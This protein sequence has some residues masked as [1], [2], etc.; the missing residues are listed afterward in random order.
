MDDQGRKLQFMEAIGLSL[1][2][3]S[4]GVTNPRHQN[5]TPAAEATANAN[6]AKRTA[7]QKS[8]SP[9]PEAISTLWIH[10]R[11]AFRPTN[12]FFMAATV[13]KL[14]E[15]ISVSYTHLTLPTIYSV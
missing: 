13:A 2:T 15:L 14:L 4:K 1:V 6:H 3:Q 11:K 9:K 5:K 8:A 12:H 10:N 7:N